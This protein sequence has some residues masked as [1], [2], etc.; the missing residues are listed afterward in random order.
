MNNLEDYVL[1]AI[2]IVDAWELEEPEFADA[3]NEQV[4]LMAYGPDY[5]DLN[6]TTPLHF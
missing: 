3:V 2:N 5:A 6:A 1:E 4:L